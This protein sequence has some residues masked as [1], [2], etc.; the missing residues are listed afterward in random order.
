VIVRDS[1]SNILARFGCAVPPTVQYIGFRAG[2][3]EYLV[4]RLVEAWG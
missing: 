4:V 1:L 2:P 3:G